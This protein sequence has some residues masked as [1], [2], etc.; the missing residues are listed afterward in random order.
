MLDNM[1]DLKEINEKTDKLK[2][3]Y[4][5]KRKGYGTRCKVCNSSKCDE[6]EDL[7]E[8]GY[9][10][11]KI[12]KELKLKDVI[13]QM[14]LSRHFTFHYKDSKKYKEYKALLEEKAILKAIEYYPPIKPYFMED[15]EDF[16]E[17]FFN[18]YGFCTM[19]QYLCHIIPEKK[20]MYPEEVLS[21]LEEKINSYDYHDTINRLKFMEH[22]NSC[23]NCQFMNM[24]ANY[25]TLFEIVLKQLFDKDFDYEKEITPLLIDEDYNK[26]VLI[27]FFKKKA[28]S[29]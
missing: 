19:N 11:S 4:D 10:Y 18:H 28:K 22:L 12:I 15:Y 25:N 24:Q 17:T 23:Y 27:N 16:T 8:K 29:K 14:S 21:K 2:I 7:R 6:I 26:E 5:N 20:I 9:S 1:K 3:K 13:S